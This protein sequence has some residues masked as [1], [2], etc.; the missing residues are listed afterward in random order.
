MSLLILR[1]R[2]AEK[3]YARAANAFSELYFKT[4]GKDPIVG[5]DDDGVSDLVLI[6]SDAVNDFLMN[7][8]LECRI[9][10]LGIR[11]GTDDYCIRTY[12]S[13][14][15]R[16]LILAGGRGRSTVYAVYDYFERF[17]G[18]H[19]FWDGD[20]IPKVESVPLEGIDVVEAPR[21]EFRGLRYFAH[22]GLKRFQAELWSLDDWKREI[23]FL[24]KKR[25][26]FFML[27]IGMDDTWQRAFPDIVPYPDG[28]ADHTDMHGYDDRSDIFPLKYRGEL[29]VKVM[30][31]AREN[32]LL[33][34]TD[35]GTM[36]HWYSRTPVEF[37][38]A[39]KPEFLGQADNQYNSNDTGKVFD[40][41]I[42]KNMDDYMKLTETMAEQFD[43]NNYLFHTIGLGERRIYKDNA[44][45]F[46]LKKAC[47]RRI[48]Q[49][50]RQRYPNSKLLIGSWDFTGWWQPSEVAEFV[51]ELDPERTIIFDYTSEGR[52]DTQNF[53]NWGIVGKFPWIFGLFHGYLPNSEL[54]GPY[55]RTAERLKIAKDD[56]FCKGMILWPELSHS[57][58]IVLEYLS[59]NAWSPLES[60]VEKLVEGYCSARYGALSERMNECWQSFLPFMKLGDWGG[61]TKRDDATQEAFATTD[62][63]L[64]HH[65]YWTYPFR[66]LYLDDADYD[67]AFFTETIAAAKPHFNALSRLTDELTQIACEQN[68][69]F[70]L[71]DSIDIVRTICGQL[72]NYMFAT[73]LYGMRD[74]S[75][76]SKLRDVYLRLMTLLAD[77]LSFNDDFSVAKTLETLKK[78]ATV[79]P[80]A[81][82][83]LKNNIS[84]SYCW[85]YCTE[86]FDYMFIDASRLALDYIISPYP[87]EEL[88]LKIGKLYEGHKIDE[89]FMNTP[90][91]QM[92]HECSRSLGAVMH[93]IAQEIPNVGKLI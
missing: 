36:T 43:D 71:R 33:S 57:D 40:F 87:R 68:D 55:D 16:V 17:V 70:V 52:D 76:L 12:K 92:K 89:R 5:L 20:V 25:L 84:N 79:N 41:R 4:C 11:Y 78:E 67:K 18:C 3:A 77:L 61:F 90:F 75:E 81:E 85:Q 48:A 73:A 2:Y 63:Y 88:E 86:L 51:K 93:D 65:D 34:P 21:F 37:L 23:D 38:Q 54:R 19:Y 47:Y 91:S 56:P 28:F 58:P 6:G 26:N 22:R 32:D 24:M 39:E 66:F 15:R 64:T 46:A 49:N 44:K 8:M 82:I 42:Q 45:N 72:L 31:Y 59:A 60:S 27:R 80:N 10:D 30:E 7:E 29:R 74:K 83:T 69:T 14:E 13:G 1:P 50:L 62:H 53:T 9:D 35:C